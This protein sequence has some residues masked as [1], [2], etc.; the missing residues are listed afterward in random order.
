MRTQKKLITLAVILVVSAFFGVYGHAVLDDHGAGEVCVV[1]VFMQTGGAPIGV[2]FSLTL[3]LI[4]FALRVSAFSFLA[5]VL[6]IAT[7]GR[8][9]PIS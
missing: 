9:P 5:V 3:F 2:V 7:P 8:S 1:C 4:S 6:S